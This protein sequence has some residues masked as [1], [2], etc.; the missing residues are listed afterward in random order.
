MALG[1]VLD[2]SNRHF[3]RFEDSPCQPRPPTLGVS[4]TEGEGAV[5][6]RTTA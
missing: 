2:F 4:A 5:L 1:N 3:N 6:I